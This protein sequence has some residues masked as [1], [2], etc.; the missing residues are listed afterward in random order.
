MWRI[1]FFIFLGFTALAPLATL[2]Y[3]H[4]IEQISRFISESSLPNL[5]IVFVDF[6]D[7]FNT[8]QT[9]SGPQ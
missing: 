8:W 2:V 9:R 6:M 7:F 1:S 3:L 4:G 5:C